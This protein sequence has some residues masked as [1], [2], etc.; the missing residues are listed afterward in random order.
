M[1]RIKRP[2]SVK[3]RTYHS[4]CGCGDIF[5]TC[6]D[7]DGK[8]FEVFA[9]LGKAGGCGQANKTSVGKLISTALRSGTDPKDL[10]KAIDGVSCHMANSNTGTLS[11]LDAV[12]QDIKLHELE[13]T[14][15]L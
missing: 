3:S 15:L 8:L 9:T 2:K 5:T 11:C 12:A 7:L 6:S 14:K 4:R 13:K 1:T 10:I